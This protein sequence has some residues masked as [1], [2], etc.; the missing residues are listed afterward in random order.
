MKYF[1]YIMSLMFVVIFIGCEKAKD[2]TSDVK[3]ATTIVVEETGG[4]VKEHECVK[5]EEHK[6]VGEDAK[7]HKCVKGECCK[8]KCDRDKSKDDVKEHKCGEGKCGGD[9]T[10]DV[11][12]E[13]IDN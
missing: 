8:S 6:C 4:T 9:E 7:E 13:V 3:E 1:I 2:T 10:K 11:A 12:K 5:G